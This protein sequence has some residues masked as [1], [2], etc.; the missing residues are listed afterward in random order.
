M[1]EKYFSQTLRL[2]YASVCLALCLILPFLTGQIPK[3]GNMLAPMHIPVL[4]GGLLCGPWYGLLLGTVLPAL[5]SAVTGM[6]VLYPM[7]PLMTAELMTYGLVAGLLQTKTPLGKHKW[8][9]Y[10]S[11]IAAMLAGRAVYGLTFYLL[12]SLDPSMKAAS[13]WTAITVGLPGIAVQLV[14]IPPIV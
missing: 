6:P 14:L 10:P 2:V 12:L 7:L 9:I 11:L 1:K 5:N 8:G 4:L 13:V 3:I